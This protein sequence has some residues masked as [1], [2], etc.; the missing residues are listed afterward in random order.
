[1]EV[2]LQEA[3]YPEREMEQESEISEKCKFML[4]RLQKE[5]SKKQS[6]EFDNL[7]VGQNKSAKCKSF[8]ELLH[9]KRKNKID[10]GK[11]SSF[12]QT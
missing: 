4:Q 7:T 1:M 10:L 11:C 3:F 12:I 8:M 5:L 2:P 9:L 6:V